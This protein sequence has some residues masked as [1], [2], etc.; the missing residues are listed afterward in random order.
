V[1]LNRFRAALRLVLGVVFLYAAYVK[2][3]NGWPLFA[4]SIESYGIL[5]LGAVV[6][7][8]RLLPWIEMALG[9]WLIAGIFPRTAAVFTALLLGGFLVLM[10]SARLRGMTIDCGCFGPGEAISWKTLLRDGSL[11]LAAVFLAVS[12]TVARRC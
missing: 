4:M 6:W 8:A 5:P 1:N 2:L 3:K 9:A 7:L 12:Q 10:V 11:A